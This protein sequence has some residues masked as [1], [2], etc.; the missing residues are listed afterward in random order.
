MTVFKEIDK[1]LLKFIWNNKPPQIAKA[2]LGIK[3]MG[4]VTFPN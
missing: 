4:G 2:I 1:T 3:K